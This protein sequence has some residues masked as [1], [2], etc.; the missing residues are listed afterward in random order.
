MIMFKK[1]VMML[2]VISLSAPVL[3]AGCNTVGGVGK[4]ITKAGDEIQE[5]AAEHKDKD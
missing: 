4:D 1:I 5:E 3:L 2:A